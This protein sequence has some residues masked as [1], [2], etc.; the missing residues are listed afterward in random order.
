MQRI[1]TQ[2]SLLSCNRTSAREFETEYRE[3]CI[4]THIMTSTTQPDLMM[5]VFAH[6]L[7]ADR[8][9]VLPIRNSGYHI[10]CVS[11]HKGLCNYFT[12]LFFAYHYKACFCFLLRNVF[13]LACKLFA[14]SVA[15]SDI[16]VR[17][18]TKLWYCCR[19]AKVE[20][21]CLQKQ[22]KLC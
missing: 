1:C 19:L 4:G 17:P 5:V 22:F 2:V 9:Q 20:Q 10:H 11:R 14:A 13:L 18:P 12:K 7:F 21:P 16:V 6:S 3:S 8:K 15:I